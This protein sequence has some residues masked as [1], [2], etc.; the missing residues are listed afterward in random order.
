MSQIS[1]KIPLVSLQHICVRGQKTDILKDVC[2]KVYAGE[3]VTVIGPNGAGKT[4]LL[5]VVLGIL[6]PESG[7]VRR[8]K[9][10]IVGYMPQKLSLPKMIPMTAKRFLRL[11]REYSFEQLK[12]VLQT[13]GIEKLAH[14]DVHSFS[15]G[16]LQRLLLARALL[17]K[18]DLLV[19]DE[20]VQGLDANGMEDFY[21]LLDV[22]NKTYNCAVLMVSHDLHVV[23][24]STNKVICLNGHICCEGK[25][26]EIEKNTDFETMFQKRKRLAFYA[27]RHDHTH[28]QDGRIVYD[29]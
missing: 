27:H 10:L 14:H 19:L 5:K 25:P 21:E 11:D 26:S 17:R 2:L 12:E 9:N 24:S 28:T 13:T 1:E 29:D 4:T 15:G 16:E 8:K 7:S 23:M 6:K 22:L 18:P 20:P 3:I